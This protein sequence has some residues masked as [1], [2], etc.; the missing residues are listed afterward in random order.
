MKRYGTED[1]C[2]AALVSMRWPDGFACPDCGGTVHS[3]SKE[4]RIFQC[5]AFRAQ[6]SAKAGTIFHKSKTPLDMVP[7]DV[8]DP[9]CQERHL[10][11]R[12]G[13]PARRQMGH[14][15]AHQAEA[16]GGHAPAQLDL[17]LKGDVQIDDAYPGSE[18]PTR[19][20]K[21]GRGAAN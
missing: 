4:R 8:S 13:A 18:A 15:M 5:S 20:C 2:H 21:T 16:D 14:G 17:H 19:P 12:A 10:R 9:K 6:I 3:Y 7:R 1:Q 11:P